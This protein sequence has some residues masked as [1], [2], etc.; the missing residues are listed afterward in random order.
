[1]FENLKLY[2]AVI[3]AVVIPKKE[4]NNVTP[5]ISKIVLATYFGKTVDIKCVQRPS[6]EPMLINTKK[7][8]GHTKTI[9]II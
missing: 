2:L 1:M 5:S 8:T 7:I 9:E 3:H 4:D 6:V